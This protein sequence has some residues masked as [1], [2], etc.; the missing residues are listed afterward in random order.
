[1]SLPAP[2]ARHHLRRLLLRALG[3]LPL[4]PSH[5]PA[6]PPARLL[7][8]RPDH[9]GDVLLATPALARLREALP[10]AHLAVAVGP[11]ASEVVRRGPAHD[12]VLTM[13]FPPFVRGAKRSR[14]APYA[15]LVQQ[16]RRL[17]AE[18]YDVALILRPDYWWGALLAWAAGIPRR[19]GYEVAEV[20]PFCTERLP[21][22]DGLHATT[23]NLALVDLLIGRAGPMTPAAAPLVFRVAPAEHA[24]AAALLRPL[25]GTA[26]PLVAIQ[27]GAGEPIKQWPVE[28]WGHVAATLARAHAAR[29][30]LTGSPAEAALTG[31]IAS[32]IAGAPVLDLAGRTDLGTLG[33]IFAASD[34]VLGVDSGG[35]HIA[36]ATAPRTLR[37]YGP[38]D[39]LAFGPW[40]DPLRHRLLRA[41]LRCPLCHHLDR[42]ET[43]PPDCMGA[44]APEQVIAAA[45][46]LLAVPV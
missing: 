43:C 20:A 17:R 24:E 2:R 27:P 19:I 25:A 14:L 18:R 9:L 8:I 21:L 15:L 32:A 38:S 4:P 13:P 34:L 33:G 23:L 42:T 44:I 41:G 35:L 36:T 40:G 45:R 11:W 5:R 28:R 1:M 46:D 16:A 3:R 26:G 10:A 31:R 39:H 12:A 6:A 22:P 29:L 7:V 37:L 30:V